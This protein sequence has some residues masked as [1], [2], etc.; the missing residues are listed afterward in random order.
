[1]IKEGGLLSYPIKRYEEIEEEYLVMKKTV[2]IEGKAID[3]PSMPKIHS[4]LDRDDE[5]MRDNIGELE[6]FL[7]KLF[8]EEAIMDDAHLR[9]KMLEFLGYERHTKIIPKYRC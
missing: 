6:V 3:L 9:E 8:N 4:L 2:K 5:M 7:R 1:M